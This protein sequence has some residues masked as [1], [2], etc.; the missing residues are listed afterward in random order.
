MKK[1][2]YFILL[3]LLWNCS[4]QFFKPVPKEFATQDRINKAKGFAKYIFNKCDT[5]DYS[6]IQGYDIDTG[7]KSSRFTSEK[8]I[9]SCEKLSEKYGKITV[10]ELYNTITFT[11]PA[12][13]SDLMIFNA[14]SEKKDSVKYV[15]IDI[16][17]DRDYIKDIYFMNKSKPKVHIKHFEI[18]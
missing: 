12:D 18:E 17:R 7:L 6:E 3:S 2:F 10:G 4:P 8:L 9:K 16:Y 11:Q 15:V 14:K 5:K 13:F 1:I